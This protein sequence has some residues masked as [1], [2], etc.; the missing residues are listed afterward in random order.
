MITKRIIICTI[1]GVIAGILCMIGGILSGNITEITFMGIFPLFFNRMM[2]GF[3]IGISN[4]K[5]HYLLHGAMVGLLIS[6][7]S[8]LLIIEESTIGFI[9]FSTAGIIYGAL[10]DWVATKLFKCPYTI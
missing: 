10:I 5:M 4:L 9:L 1:G 2:L 6:L 3:I 7:I 8:S